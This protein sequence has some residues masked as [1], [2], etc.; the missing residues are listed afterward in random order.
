MEDKPTI[1]EKEVKEIKEAIP[2]T[3]EQEVKYII[4]KVE[5]QEPLYHSEYSKLLEI[6]EKEKEKLASEADSFRMA[7]EQ[8]SDKFAAITDEFNK[9]SKQRDT[10]IR[11]I[12]KL[13]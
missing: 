4:D 1:I 7:Y 9:V 8:M 12:D 2:R 10:L 6:A 3:G 13:I 5:K 11:M